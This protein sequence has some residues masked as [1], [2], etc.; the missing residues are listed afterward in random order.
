VPTSSVSNPSSEPMMPNS[1]GLS[2]RRRIKQHRPARVLKLLRP[3]G[4]G[5]A[6]TTAR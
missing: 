2:R 3:H 4:G 5:R 1:S 6:W